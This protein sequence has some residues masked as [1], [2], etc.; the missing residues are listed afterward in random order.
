[1]TIGFQ[2]PHFCYIHLKYD[3]RNFRIDLLVIKATRKFFQP[4]MWVNKFFNITCR[5]PWYFTEKYC[6]LL[7]YDN[8]LDFTDNNHKK[9]LYLN[10]QWKSHQI[11]MELMRIIGC[12]KKKIRSRPLVICRKS[13]F[14][15]HA[16]IR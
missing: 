11:P 1:M 8:E 2:L 10:I 13:T 4:G 9:F 7:E 3:R 15:S 14:N 16:K 12:R 6:L 5:I